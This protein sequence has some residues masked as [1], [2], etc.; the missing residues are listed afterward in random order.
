MDL[1]ETSLAER[2]GVAPA[3]VLPQHPDVAAWRPATT[4]DI[5]GIWQLRRAMGEVDHP[6]YLTARGA[7]AADFGYSHFHAELDSLVGIDAA[8]SI[9]AVG[10]VMF[11][12]RQV[13]LVRSMPI[14]G[15][16]PRLRGR[17]IGRQLL[18]WQL[19]RAKQQL[20]S[21]TTTLPGWILS[22]ADERSPQN[23]AL[24]EH[25]GLSL[26]RYFLTLER[27]LDASVRVIDPA[28]GIRVAAYTAA[29]S[30]E[31]HRTRDDSF[32][33]HWGSQPMSDENWNA[34]VGGKWFRPDL[35][36]V[37]YGTDAAGTEQV[38]GFVL[39]TANENIWAM[40]GF[41]G[42]YIDLVGVL[43]G[44]RGRHIAQSLLAAQL[45][46]GQALGHE[47]VTL[48]VDSASP[49]GALGLYTGM[50]FVPTHKKMAYTLE[51]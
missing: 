18:A 24:F 32:M 4:A 26:A 10:M 11:P 48:A 38:V 2:V 50:G 22:Y 34:F 27:P 41:T 45:A 21:S 44:W 15:V 13:S 49:T 25:A 36:F 39:S 16:H 20:A 6:N 28:A 42:S 3:P 47:R 23:A 9:L 19:G 40:Q 8:G 37:A 7:I 51:F 1:H 35:S 31:V 30:A 46:A 14:G 17:G 12:P 29:V 33:D 43:S 5:D